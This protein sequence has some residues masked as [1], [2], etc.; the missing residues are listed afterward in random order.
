MT[1]K[2]ELLFKNRLLS[3][4]FLDVVEKNRQF[5]DLQQDLNPNVAERSKN[6]ENSGV[7]FLPCWNT[8]VIQ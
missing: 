3:S 6:K 4:S 5:M 1:K 7:Y 2:P 8:V